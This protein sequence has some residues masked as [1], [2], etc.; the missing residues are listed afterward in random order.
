MIEHQSQNQTGLAIGAM[1]GKYRLERLLEQRLPVLS[2]LASE[3]I[4]QQYYRLWALALPDLVPED[5]VIYLGHFQ[6]EAGRLLTLQHPNLLSLSDYGISQGAPYL[7]ASYSPAQSLSSLL[8]QQGPLDFLTASRYLDQLVDGLEYAHQQSIW[9]LNLTTDC[10]LLRESGVLVIAELGI[11]RILATGA[12]LAVDRR[13]MDEPDFTPGAKG[14][15]FYGLSEASAPAPELLLGSPVGAPADVYGL[16]ALLYRLL[17][18]RPVFQ[19]RTPTEMVHQHLNVAMPSLRGWRPGVSVDIDKLLAVALSKDPARRFQRPEAFAHAYRQLVAPGD[20]ESQPVVQTSPPPVILSK[21]QT[22]T[23]GNMPALKPTPKQLR[24]PD[25]RTDKPFTRR[26]LVTLLV[27]GT[28]VAATVTTVTLFAR[29]SFVGSA[30]T[31][32][33]VGQSGVASPTTTEPSGHGTVLARTSD[34]PLNSAK[35]FPLA[36]SDN[37][38]LL[39]HLPDNRFVAFDSTCTHQSCAVAYNTSNKLLEC[40][41]HGAVFDPSKNASVV[42]GPAPSP[43]KAI[44]ITVQTDGTVTTGNN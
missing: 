44:A 21:E 19:S 26:R 13:Q 37:P 32:T 38:G 36:G 15:P 43:L 28:A 33:P 14:R 35:S 9:H 12:K 27:A 6:Q 7:V 22:P 2:F 30:S 10:V 4:T 17:T 42:Q 3:P 29:G 23:S 25:S 8:Y 39:I 41:C 11:A 24:A 1:L 34:V 40:P 18:G 16:G 5:R 31:S 20:T